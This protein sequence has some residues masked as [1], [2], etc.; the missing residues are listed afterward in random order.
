MF[1]T[2]THTHTGMRVHAH[3]H[4]HIH[5]QNPARSSHK[6]TP[7][8]AERGGR[9]LQVVDDIKS[10]LFLGAEREA[11]SLDCTLFANE[12][13]TMHEK[14]MHGKPCFLN[15]R[16]IEVQEDNGGVITW[17]WGYLSYL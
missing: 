10:V 9:V 7:P 6:H 12:N 13:Y 5:T 15:G 14:W 2:H 8:E 11:A 1:F 16:E 17:G 4:T 3:T